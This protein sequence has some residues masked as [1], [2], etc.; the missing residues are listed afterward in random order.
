MKRQEVKIQQRQPVIDGQYPPESVEDWLGR[1]ENCNLSPG[2]GGFQ[3]PDLFDER[4]FEGRMELAGD[5]LQ[6]LGMRS[7]ECGV[8]GL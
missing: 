5:N 7:V 1:S 6:H 4:G 8:W 3:T 2:I